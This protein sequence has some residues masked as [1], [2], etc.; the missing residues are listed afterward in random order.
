MGRA[1]PGRREASRLAGRR[2][3]GGLAGLA[4]RVGLGTTAA[5]AEAGAAASAADFGLTMSPE[6]AAE[7]AGGGT[8]LAGLLGSGAAGPIGIA[9]ALSAF[10]MN[11]LS[12]TMPTSQMR[13]DRRTAG[14][15][16]PV[17]RRRKPRSDH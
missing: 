8:G 12:G 16:Q 2:E 14:R 7:F 3:F 13:A 17:F 6:F 1:D 10:T 5:T 15:D 11:R 9:A 4:E